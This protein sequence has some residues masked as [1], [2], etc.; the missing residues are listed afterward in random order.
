MGN[1][2]IE[3]DDLYELQLQVIELL[4]KHSSGTLKIII[5]G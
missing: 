5:P 2:Q 3:E 4:L 1:M